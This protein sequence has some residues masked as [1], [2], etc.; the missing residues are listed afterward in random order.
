MNEEPKPFTL[1]Q[2]LSIT[3][4]RLLCDIGGVYEIL[5][6]ITGD[7]LFTHQ[8]PRA[9]RFAAPLLLEL[10]PE[11]QRAT[12]ELG[13]LDTRLA[14]AKDEKQKPQVAIQAWLNWLAF[15]H[16]YLEIP[17]Y[18]DRWLSLDPVGELEGMVGREKV[19]TVGM[20]RPTSQ[21]EGE[22]P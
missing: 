13:F 4:E 10:Y 6:H 8:L 17:S 9:G 19:V 14:I 16:V 20:T 1:A 15:P 3:T 22:K 12:D 18:A 11:L 2:V 21:P 7:S 5:N